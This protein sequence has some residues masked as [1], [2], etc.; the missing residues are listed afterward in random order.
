MSMCGLFLVDVDPQLR[1]TLAL[2]LVPSNLSNKSTLCETLSLDEV[3]LWTDQ[4][5]CYKGPVGRSHRNE[6]P[7]VK[8]GR[9]D[10]G[11]GT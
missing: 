8:T 7:T 3:S 5:S 11:Q 1:L 4:D 2:R 10:D 9:S 6:T